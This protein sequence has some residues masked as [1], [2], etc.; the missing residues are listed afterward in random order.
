VQILET[1]RLILREITADDA[2]FTL[3]LLNQPSFIKYIGDRGVRDL[4]QSRDFIENRYRKSYRDNGYGLYVVDLKNPASAT[5]TPRL[6]DKESVPPAV[7]GGLSS[8]ASN[9]DDV[10]NPHSIGICG[11]VRRSELPAP[12][13]GFAFLPQYEKNGYGFESA[14]AVMQYGHKTLNFECVLAITS[15]DNEASGKLL[16]KLGFAFERFVHSPDGEK[17][18]LFSRKLK[19]M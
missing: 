4:D 5:A 2:A 14:S 16:L 1:E 12:D 8:V 11:F 15:P 3:D 9:A 17:L 18:K 13:I 6:G 19:L 7:A 10:S